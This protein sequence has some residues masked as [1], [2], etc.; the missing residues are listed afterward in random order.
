MLGRRPVILS[1][2]KGRSRTW[3]W[4]WSRP[5]EAMQVK[6]PAS[7][8]LTR[9]ITRAPS[10]CCLCLGGE[11]GCPSFCHSMVRAGDASTVQ[12]SLTLSPTL[13][14][15][16]EGSLL[17]ILNLYVNCGCTEEPAAC[18]TFPPLGSSRCR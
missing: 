10:D 4:S 9:L 7:S 8:E 5:F 18:I 12:G 15:T 14:S 1:P 13:V 3:R 16:T 2:P 17:S 6:K 11:R